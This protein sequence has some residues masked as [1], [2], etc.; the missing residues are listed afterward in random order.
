[1]IKVLLV[2]LVAL[3]LSAQGFRMRL[4]DN[5]TK[6][7]AKAAGCVIGCS[8]ATLLDKNLANNCY[9]SCMNS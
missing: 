3:I 8:G 7:E 1:M 5:N 4:E 6:R 2:L 9:N